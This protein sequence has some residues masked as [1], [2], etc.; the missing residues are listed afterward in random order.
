MLSS[1]VADRQHLGEGSQPGVVSRLREDLDLYRG[2]P[3]NDGSSTWTLHDPVRN[4][5]FTL[6]WLEFE[7][8]K[9]WSYRSFERIA[10][11][12]TRETTLEASPDDVRILNEFLVGNELASADRNID[13]VNLYKRALASRFRLSSFLL[14]RYLFFRVPL[15]RPDRFLSVTM[16]YIAPLFSRVFLWLMIFV[17]GSGSY[18]VLRQWPA[19]SQN[20]GYLF[21]FEGLV[22]F[23]LALIFAKCLHELGHAYA[24][25]Y[26]GL[27]VPTMG[28][29][30]LVMWP[31]LYT[32][33][34]ES[35][36]LASRRQRIAIG[37]AGVAAELTLAAVCTLLWSFLEDGPARYAVFF[38]ATAS[39]I[40]T[41]AININPFM[42]WDGYY[43]L[44]DVLGVQNLQARAFALGRWR[45][46]EFLFGLGEPPP[47]IFDRKYRRILLLYAYST[48]I[49][50]FVLF[51]GIALL[52]YHF[53]FK[54]LGLFLMAVEVAW[55]IGRPFYAE[56]RAWFARKG[57]IVW[58]KNTLRTAALFSG[59]LAVL[60]VPW[61]THVSAPA[62]VK[63]KLH[64]T[65]Y[66]PAPARV[67]AV[68]IIR[69]QNVKKGDALI[70]L[71]S[72]E[73]E[74]R[75]RKAG[76]RIEMY[77][78]SL[79]R[80]GSRA[81]REDLTVVQQQLQQALAAYRGYQEQ[82]EQLTITAPFDGE[83][84]MLE[85]DLRPGRWVPD[86]LALARLVDKQSVEIQ[87]YLTERELQRLR[88]D[89]RSFFYPE[90]PRLDPIPARII[91]VDRAS[92]V[93]IDEAALA[94]VF[95]GPLAVR[96]LAGGELRAEQALYRVRLAFDRGGPRPHATILRGTVHVPARR[97]SLLLSGWQKVS[98]VL[99]RESGF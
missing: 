82:L 51:L 5:F 80:M 72:P 73:F 87:A 63:P 74:I 3:A 68:Q 56:L 37:A 16:P 92:T 50:R 49:Y 27:K 62:I 28:V 46:R 55:F 9:R 76:H 13:V 48:W 57:A 23:A 36:K 43:L 81:F 2:A 54:A 69:H 39:W 17:A 21:S 14:H 67:K 89:A 38:L 65:F 59:L 25:R 84:V 95:G 93:S 41:L 61:N 47:E 4:K 70:G 10:L 12:V 44:A 78:S 35:W 53:F 98:A 32:D 7:L 33:T 26:Y 1:A 52:V 40:M 79:E 94:S 90:N 99:V 64:K 22:Y 85:T 19:F 30:F 77:R 86:D 8:L 15:V 97:Q 71:E 96:E 88:S 91:D 83:I 11:A 20:F 42:R 34:T 60:M 29:A 6:G 75:L 45:L 66:A 58:N 24:C 31:F 18:L